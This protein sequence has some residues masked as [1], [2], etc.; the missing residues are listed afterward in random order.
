VGE[1]RRKK[2]YCDC[3]TDLRNLE[4]KKR[5]EEQKGEKIA[6]HFSHRDEKESPTNTQQEPRNRPSNI[7]PQPDPNEK[8]RFPQ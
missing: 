5:K 7:Q 1:I 4:Q 2:K 3:F 6:W 8:M